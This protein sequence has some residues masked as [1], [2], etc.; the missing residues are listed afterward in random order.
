MEQV[1]LLARL[2]HPY[3]LS[4][5]ESFQYKNHLCIVTENCEGGDLYQKLSNSKGYLKEE[6]IVDCLCQVCL[7]LEYIHERK[8]LHR[9]LKTQNVFLHHDGT[10]KLGDFGIAR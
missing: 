10:C 2:S 5:V 9:D 7:A 6:Q 1:K 8:V 3:V 4:Y